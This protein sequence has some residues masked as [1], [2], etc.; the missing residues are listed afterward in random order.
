MAKKKETK[1][2]IAADVRAGY[3]VSDTKTA[4][5]RKS[6][7]N[8]DAVAKA[9]RGLDTDAL[10]K[11]AKDEGGKELVERF[12]GWAKKLNAGQVRMTLGNAVRAARRNAKKAA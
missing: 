2:L 12:D 10:R 6:V 4:G 8:N 7:D 9:M 3:H 1:S 11:F 5:G